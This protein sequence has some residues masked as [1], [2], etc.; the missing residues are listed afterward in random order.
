VITA[1]S[2]VVRAF[3]RIGWEWGGT[4]RAGEDYQHFSA[5]EIAIGN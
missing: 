1:N 5:T 4:W 3:A 2:L